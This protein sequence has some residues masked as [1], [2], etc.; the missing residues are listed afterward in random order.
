MFGGTQRVQIPD[1]FWKVVCSVKGGALQVFAFILEQDLKGLN[2]EFQ[3]T[4]EWKHRQVSLRDLEAAVVLVRFPDVY[5]RADQ[6]GGAAPAK[7]P[8]KRKIQ[9]SG[10]VAGGA[11]PVTPPPPGPG[12]AP[13]TPPGPEGA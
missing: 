4:A 1:R 5:H 6:A 2:L 13:L 3:P 11:P 10:A 12:A 9:V 7:A 8:R